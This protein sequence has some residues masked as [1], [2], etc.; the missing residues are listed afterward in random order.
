MGLQQQ[1]STYYECRCRC[2]DS[3]EVQK[4]S[5]KHKVKNKKNKIFLYAEELRAEELKTHF[6]RVVS[7]NKKFFHCF[8][9]F[10]IFFRNLVALA[11]VYLIEAKEQSKSGL[12]AEAEKKFHLSL[13]HSLF[14][15][16]EQSKWFFFRWWSDIPL[17]SNHFSYFVTIYQM[18]FVE[19]SN[20]FNQ[21]HLM[22]LIKVVK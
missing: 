14:T 21:H 20:Y 10:S 18:H 15:K 22:L 9:L 8:V 17:L 5:S 2:R 4:Q 13:S 19:L 1:S 7:Q 11:A 12:H 16:I 6:F 3:E